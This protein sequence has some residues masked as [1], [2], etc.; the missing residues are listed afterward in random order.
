[1]DAWERGRQASPKPSVS[2]LPLLSIRIEECKAV[3]SLLSLPCLLEQT[4]RYGQHYARGS[5]IR[6]P[7]VADLNSL[8]LSS[9]RS[10]VVNPIKHA[11]DEDVKIHNTRSAL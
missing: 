8:F 10:L 5:L 4:L 1:M 9:F 2:Q 6:D 11:I 7:D 3:S